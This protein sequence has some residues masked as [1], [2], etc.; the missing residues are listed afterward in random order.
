MRVRLTEDIDET[1][2][3]FD[4]AKNDDLTG[5]CAYGYDGPKPKA[6]AALVLYKSFVWL[7]STLPFER[8][9]A[10]LSVSL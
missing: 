2:C 6:A 1:L 5:V 7:S 9:A 3:V 8:I 10:V 4:N